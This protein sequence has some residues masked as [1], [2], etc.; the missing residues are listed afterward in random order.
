MA[1]GP[2]NTTQAKYIYCARNPKDVAVSFYHHYMKMKQIKFDVSWDEFVEYFLRGDSFFGSWWDHVPEWWTHRDEPNVLF[3]K[4]EDLKKDLPGNVKT[5]AEFLGC[6]VDEA[7]IQKIAQATTFENMK[8]NTAKWTEQ[9]MIRKGEV[10]DWK[11]HFTPAQSEAFDALYKKAI[12]G[13]G[14]EMEFD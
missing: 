3:L 4:Y 9:S 11:N 6:S 2:P 8:V 10:G 1:G 5:I 13:T 14:L 12:E 7:T